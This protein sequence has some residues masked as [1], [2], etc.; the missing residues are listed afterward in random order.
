MLYFLQN[1]IYIVILSF[2]IQVISF[3]EC[4]TGTTQKLLIGVNT[5]IELKNITTTSYNT[6]TLLHQNIPC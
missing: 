2:S 4:N 1:A 6:C 5:M 3:T